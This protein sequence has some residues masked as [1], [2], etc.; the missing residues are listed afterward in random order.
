MVCNQ[1]VLCMQEYSNEDVMVGSWLLGLSVE[2]IFDSAFCCGDFSVCHATASSLDGGDVIR[3]RKHPELTIATRDCS[4]FA[5]GAAKV[6][7][8]NIIHEGA[9]TCAMFGGGCNGVCGL[10]LIHMTLPTNREV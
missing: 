2:H 3:R 10:S 1:T 9:K 4:E 7:T 8:P 6:L 5:P